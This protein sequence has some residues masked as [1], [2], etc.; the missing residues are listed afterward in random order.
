MPR[1]TERGTAGEKLMIQHHQE[2]LHMEHVLHV[3]RGHGIK[4]NAKWLP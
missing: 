1:G 4:S 3:A 2:V